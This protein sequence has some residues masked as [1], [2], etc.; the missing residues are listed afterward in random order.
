MPGGTE[1]PPSMWHRPFCTRDPDIRKISGL[2]GTFGRQRE[3]SLHR[4]T[5][6]K[7]GDSKRMPLLG[8]KGAKWQKPEGTLLSN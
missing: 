1:W 5:I 6:S 8:K 3:P 7:D 2:P 4:L